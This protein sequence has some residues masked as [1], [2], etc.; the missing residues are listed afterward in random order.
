MKS[1]A[2]KLTVIKRTRADVVFDTFNVVLNLLLLFICLY[3]LYFVLCA[4]VSDPYAVARGEV[5]LFPRGF[6]WEPYQ[7]VFKEPRIWLGYR[8]TLFYSTVGTLFSL[9]LTIPSAYALSKRRL[10]GRR[11]FNIYFLIPMYFSGGLIPTYLT[12]KQLGVVNQWYTLIFIGASSVYNM[13]VSRVYSS[14][15]RCRWR[16]PFWRSCRCF[17]LW[18]GGTIISMPW[19]TLPRTIIC[20]CR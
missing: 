15:S 3:P 11:F 17:S 13:I 20:P 12:M 7:E 5:Y 9:C 10:P 14:P 1:A 8:N 6:T 4:S 16:A 19:S 18:P 2:T